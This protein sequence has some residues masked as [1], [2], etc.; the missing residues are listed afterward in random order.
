MKSP[1]QK[2]NLME[3]SL[4]R[5]MDVRLKL[6]RNIAK[7]V[8]GI[9][10]NLYNKPI[11]FAL[12]EYIEAWSFYKFISSGKLLSIDEITESLKFEERVCDDETGNHFQLFIEVSSMD[13]LLGLSD[14]GGE[15]MR[16]AI[17]QASAGEHNVAIDVQ[18]FMCFLYGYFIFL[19]NAINNRDWQKK[20]E[21][22]HQSLT[23]I[24]IL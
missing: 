23:K 15:L 24:N 20:L 11:S 2:S 18:K 16:F 7:E 12:Q 9:D 1:E 21:V 10:Q 8:V 3:S 17:N 14:I 19:G 13:Y 22:F 6:F 4:K 5:L